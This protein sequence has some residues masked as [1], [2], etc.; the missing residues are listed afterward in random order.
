MKKFFKKTIR[1]IGFHGS[2][3]LLGLCRV[4]SSTLFTAGLIYGMYGFDQVS[5]VDGYDAV[6]AFVCS[7]LAVLLSVVGIYLTGLIFKKG[8]GK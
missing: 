8:A 5:N 6:W 2:I 7:V 4:T 1:M 3:L